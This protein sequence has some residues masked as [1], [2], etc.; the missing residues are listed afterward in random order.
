[1]KNRLVFQNGYIYLY[2]KQNSSL[3]NNSIEDFYSWLADNDVVTAYEI[4]DYLCSEGV[5]YRFGERESNL[6]RKYGKV[7]L[8]KVESLSTYINRNSSEKNTE[9][10]K[11]YY[12]LD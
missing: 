2:Y 12:C 11:W 8:H 3:K 1:M 9:Y 5:L 7:K 10:Y 6:L 4:D